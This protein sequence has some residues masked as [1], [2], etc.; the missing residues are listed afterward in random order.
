MPGYRAPYTRDEEVPE[1][2]KMK[3]DYFIEDTTEEVVM[4]E[5]NKLRQM[6]LTQI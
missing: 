1:D 6:I 5:G 3:I 4:E 2:I